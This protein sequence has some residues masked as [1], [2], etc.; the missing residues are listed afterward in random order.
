MSLYAFLFYIMLSI[1]EQYCVHS[2][3]HIFLHQVV[4]FIKAMHASIWTT[5]FKSSIIMSKS[6]QSD[7]DLFALD[8]SAIQYDCI[9]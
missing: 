8:K 7:I 4:P 2:Q 1:Y 9:L 3:T 6:L 5:N